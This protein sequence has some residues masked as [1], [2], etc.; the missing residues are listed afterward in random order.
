MTT[1]HNSA[2]KGDIAKTVLLPGDPL[3]AKF[4]A[5]NFLEDAVQFNSVRNMFGYTGTYKGQKV[6]VM[7][8]GMGIPSIGIYSYELIHFFGVENL[9]RI[10]SCGSFN[11]NLKLYDII[12]AM[13][14][15]TNSNFANQYELPGT[16]S[17]IASWELLSKAKQV[18]DEKNID[19]TIGNV[20]TGD[21]F[22][23]PQQDVWK[24]WAQ[25]GVLAAEMETYALY[26]NAAYAGVNAL[27]IL[28]V[29]DSIVT[30]EETSSEER[31]KGFTKMMEIALEVANRE[32]MGNN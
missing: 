18:A 23:S 10:G 6:S 25:M 7:G 24:K 26:C 21:N 32:G 3:R 27:T 14:A 13:G 20:Y 4:I 30:N 1:P 29:S 9:I 19:V 5:E 8:T 16:F 31:Q 15:C 17:A 28:T 2:K 12:L 22:Y 11:K